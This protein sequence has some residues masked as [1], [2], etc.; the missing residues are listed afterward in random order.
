VA[1]LFCPSKAGA[2]LKLVKNDAIEKKKG[3]VTD[4]IIS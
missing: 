2:L 3:I 1:E 4:T